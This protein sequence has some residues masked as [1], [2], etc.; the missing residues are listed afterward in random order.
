MP[1]KGDLR[2]LA[3]IMSFPALLSAPGCGYYFVGRGI[4]PWKGV[5]SVCVR[6]FT[7]DTPESGIENYF[8]QAIIAEFAR[9]KMLEL[10]CSSPDSFLDGKITSYKV[11]PYY[12]AKEDLVT[13]YQVAV[14][15]DL[16]LS[17][18]SDGESLWTLKKVS[19]AD[20]A[21]AST[22]ILTTKSFENA[23][24]S[25][26]AKRMMESVYNLLSQNF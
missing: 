5:A 23:A 9:G 24:V 22:E 25:R 7:N 12:Y 18:R 26:M 3:V 13:G 11:V 1:G 2:K 8:T 10:D 4:A 14:E 17:R 20:S 16:V 15:V 6:T 21:G 19:G